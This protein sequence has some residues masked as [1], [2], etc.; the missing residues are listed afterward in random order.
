MDI[1]GSWITPSQP[2]LD[3]TPLSGVWR[4]GDG[5]VLV[6]IGTEDGTLGWCAPGCVELTGLTSLDALET[7]VRGDATLGASAIATLDGEP[8]RAFGTDEPTLRRWIVAMHDGRPVAIRVDAGAWDTAPDIPQRLFDSFRFIDPAPAVPEQVLAD[9]G[10][11]FEVALPAGWT[12]VRRDDG[13]FLVDLD[14]E[15]LAI[16][17]GDDDGT[18]TPCEVPAGPFEQCEEITAQSLDELATAVA[19][20]PSSDPGIGPPMIRRDSTTIDGE[21]AVIFRLEAYE[22]PAK[23]GQH[24]AYVVAI[25]DGRPYIL[26][27]WTGDDRGL[28]DVDEA[29]AGF[30]FTD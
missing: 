2:D 29:I 6:S 14:G 19:P 30:R 24:L 27:F 26:R 3:G 18:V 7:A 22:P 13:V 8:A 28:R 17:V 4:F 1:P 20:A 25:H 23:G 10:G 16:R 9:P 21:P 5:E 15:R 12:Q 11:R